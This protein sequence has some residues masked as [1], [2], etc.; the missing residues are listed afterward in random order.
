MEILGVQVLGSVE[1]VEIV[2][3]KTQVVHLAAVVTSMKDL[4]RCKSLWWE[5][6][7]LKDDSIEQELQQ[8]QLTL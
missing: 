7:K 1:W 5:N 3:D 6:L 4:L 8:Q 2:Q